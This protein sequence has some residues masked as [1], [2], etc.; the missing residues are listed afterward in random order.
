MAAEEVLVANI[1][2]N[3]LNPRRTL[4]DVSKLAASI[5]NNGLL[6]PVELAACSCAQVPKAHY[7]ILDGHRRMKALRM[8]RQ[9]ALSPSEYRVRQDLAPEREVAILIESNGSSMLNTAAELHV[10]L[11]LRGRFGMLK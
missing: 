10:S 11:V 5:S 9:T 8:L 2:D 7:R 6:E 4:G 3:K 1:H